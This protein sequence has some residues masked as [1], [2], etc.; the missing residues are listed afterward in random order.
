MKIPTLET[1]RLILRPINM[2]DVPAIQ[3]YFNDWDIIK[4]TRAIWPYNPEDTVDHVKDTIYKN[5]TGH[6]IT[7]V[8]TQKD[9][10]EMIGRIDYRYNENDIGR[11]FWLAKP[12]HKKGIM[13]EAIIATQN[14]MFFERNIERIIVDNDISNVGSRRIKEKTGATLLGTKLCKDT[15]LKEEIQTWEV[16]KEAW[17]KIR[18]KD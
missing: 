7:W 2:D 15:H 5:E 10:P 9:Q 16:T 17:T 8:I 14:Y 12:H 4:Y 3:K 18:N 13:T 11:G 1:Q 6:H